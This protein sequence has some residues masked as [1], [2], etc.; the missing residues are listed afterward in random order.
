[1]HSA[2]TTGRALRPVFGLP[3]DHRAGCFRAG[4]AYARRR[5]QAAEEHDNTGDQEE[6]DN[7]GD[8][9]VQQGLGDETHDAENNRHDH[10]KQEEGKHLE[11]RPN[12][13]LSATS[14]P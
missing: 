8:Q 10:E 7:T 1:V 11:L 9:Q 12:V 6:H 13:L 3:W 5:G 2:R 14:V 4:A